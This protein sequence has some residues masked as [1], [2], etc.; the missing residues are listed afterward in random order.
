MS[1]TV[2]PDCNLLM[3]AVPARE[4]RALVARCER[5]LLVAGE[6]LCSDDVPFRFMLFP[7]S[8][9]ILASA[10]VEGPGSVGIGLIG[11]EG[12]LGT[13]LDAANAGAS[14]VGANVL[15]AGAALRLSDLQMRREMLA[16]PPLRRAVERYRHVLLRQTARL[17]A[18]NYFHE[19]G[20]RLAHWLLLVHD[21]AHADHFHLTHESLAG[22]LGVRRSGVSLAAARLQQGDSI[23]YVRGD[24][25]VLDRRRLESIA[26]SC[27]VAM[28]RIYDETMR[29]VN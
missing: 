3:K 21:R 19:I 27:H 29:R 6:T 11:C 1:P 13:P 4:R 5:I 15:V 12:M 7:L 26:C 18:C 22:L 23:H 17:A 2:P 14:A 20:P 24:I 25:E 28:R 8:G 9:A 16:S 10:Q